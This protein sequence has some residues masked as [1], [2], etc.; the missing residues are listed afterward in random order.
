MYH[1][2]LAFNHVLVWELFR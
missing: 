1:M 2:E